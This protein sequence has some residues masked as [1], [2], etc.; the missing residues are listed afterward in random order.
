[1]VNPPCKSTNHPFCIFSGMRNIAVCTNLPKHNRCSK[2]TKPA[3]FG[4]L[5][6]PKGK[7]IILKADYG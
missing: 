2:I 3:P 4:Y 1:M 5:L 7:V 6:V